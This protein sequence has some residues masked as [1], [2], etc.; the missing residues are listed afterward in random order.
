MIREAGTQRAM[1]LCVLTLRNES[2][3]HEGDE[4]D[5]DSAPRA[6][7]SSEPSR[8]D[9]MLKIATG[10]AADAALRLAAAEAEA[11]GEVVAEVVEVTATALTCELGSG[12]LVVVG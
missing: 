4:V 2:R 12:A 5:Q 10:D 3:Q 6:K 8:I 9:D 1:E 7:L 11:E